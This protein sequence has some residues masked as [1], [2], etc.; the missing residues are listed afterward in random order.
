MTGNGFVK[1]Y[2]SILDSSIWSETTTTRILWITLLAMA[3][4]DGQV[5]A[6][7]GGLARRAQVPREDVEA[8]LAVL[9]A[10]DPDDRSGVEEGR[11]LRVISRGW[12]IINHRAYRDLRTTT[13]VKTAERVKKHRHQ[14][15]A[16]PVTPVTTEEEEE[17]EED[18]RDP[19][20]AAQS[21]T[22]P[23][24]QLALGVCDSSKP[25]PRKAARR[26]K[27]PESS[28]SKRSTPETPPP[29]PRVTELRNL[30]VAEYEQAKSAKPVLAKSQW[31]RAMKAFKE[32]LDAAKEIE[33]AASIIRRAFADEWHRQNR[34]QPWE[35]VA[36]MNKLI[37][38]SP[39]PRKFNG[40]RELQS[41]EGAPDLEAMYGVK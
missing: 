30:Y 26:T 25:K 28:K 27:K 3:D 22:A 24:E 37:G 23:S 4:G 1:L 33:P 39:A 36:D 20:C 2:G 41:R 15:T 7:V 13:Q 38:A 21:A 31:P 32:L 11:R 14:K 5:S 34:C 18:Q 6:S 35:I 8:A 9:L 17:E 16:L 12:Q 10:P 19:D 29:D 40:P